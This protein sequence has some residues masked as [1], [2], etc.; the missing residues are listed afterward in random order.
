MVHSHFPAGIFRPNTNTIHSTHSLLLCLSSIFFRPE[1]SGRKI[2]SNENTIHIHCC[3]VLSCIY[4]LARTFRPEYSVQ[5]KYNIHVLSIRTFRPEYSV[6]YKYNTQWL[7]TL[8]FRPEVSGRKIKSNTNTIHIY[9]CC[10]LSLIYI[11]A[12]IFQP[13]YSVQY[14]Y[15]TFI[16]VVFVLYL[17]SGRNIS[18]LHILC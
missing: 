5:Y 1:F 11:S 17:F 13:E 6:Q 2:K 15:N 14:K 16:V 7:F 8:T 10:V 9:C 3:C 4:I 12:G 18:V